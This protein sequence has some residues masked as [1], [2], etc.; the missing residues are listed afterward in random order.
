MPLRPNDPSSRT[1]LPRDL[2]HTYPFTRVRLFKY[3]HSIGQHWDTHVHPLECYHRSYRP[4][5]DYVGIADDVACY[6]VETL[7]DAYIFNLNST[8]SPTSSPIS[9]WPV[10]NTLETIYLRHPFRPNSIQLISDQPRRRT[11]T[12][13]H[14]RHRLV[15]L[16]HQQSWRLSIFRPRTSRQS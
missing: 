1:Q 7:A 2:H 9:L 6:A 12:L 4:L 15:S 5:L 10:L 14:T 16:L 3:C 8:P 13:I 11:N